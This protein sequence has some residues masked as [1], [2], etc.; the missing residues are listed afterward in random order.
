MLTKNNHIG[1]IYQAQPQRAT[2]LMVQLLATHRGKTLEDYLKQFPIK[3]FDTDDDY[4]WEIIGSSRRN[5]A[6]VEGRNEDG[7]TLTTGSYGAAG[8]PFY[9]V[10]GEDLFAKTI[11]A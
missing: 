5:V 11:T 9:V 2:N 10:F 1:A 6:I 3:Y 8:A 4:F 7:T